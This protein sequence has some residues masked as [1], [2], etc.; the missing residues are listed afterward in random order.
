MPADPKEPIRIGFLLLPNYSMIAF[1]NAVEV[2]RMANR[3]SGR[4]LYAHHVCGAAGPETSCSNGLS[5]RAEATLAELDACE[6][7]FV[8][9]G[10]EVQAAT[11]DAVRRD[12]RQRAAARQRLG[13]LCT[14]SYAL[15]S[16]GL[17]NGYRCAIHWDGQAATRETF[18]K[19]QFVDEIFVI[20]R[21]RYTASGGTAP[22]YLLLQLVEQQFGN[23]LALAIS[24]QFILDRVRPAT[25]RQ[26]LPQPGSIGPGYQH[27]AAAVEIMAAN[28]DEPLSLAQVATRVRI[29]LRQLERMFLR[30]Y[31]I[32]PAQ[33][34]MT[35]RLRRARELLTH[36]ALPIM[37]ITVACGFQSS[38]HFCKAYRTAFGAA[39]SAVRRRPKASVDAAASASMPASTSATPSVTA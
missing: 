26:R 9:G 31:G 2:L 18:G 8:C 37:Q 38:S 32:G 20:D 19:V 3:I 35:I 1:A 36:T 22:L 17:L 7:V 10:I 25:D 27:L 29:S 21:D 28:I 15:A 14:G 23:P 5:V 11:S 34:Y 6:I 24:E 16:A 12:L 30:Y 4:N 13:S 39:P 33:H